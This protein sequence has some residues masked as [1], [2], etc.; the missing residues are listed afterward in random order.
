MWLGIEPRNN[1]TILLEKQ[2]FA[3]LYSS[4]FREIKTDQRIQ[5]VEKRKIVRLLMNKI[6]I[7]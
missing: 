3:V 7:L 4:L 1:D 6:I 2:V 5:N